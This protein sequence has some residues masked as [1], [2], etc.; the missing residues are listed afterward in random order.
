M[1][2]KLVQVATETVTSAVASVTLTGIDSDDVYMVAYNN[3]QVSG[4]VDLPMRLTIGGTADS[5]SSYE[6]AFKRLRTSASFVDGNSTGFTA[7][8]FSVRIDGTN[9]RENGIFYIYN[10][11][12]SSE[13]TFVTAE[14][15]ATSDNTAALQG[16]AGG[17]VFVKTDSVNGIQFV[18]DS[19]ANNITKGTFTLYKVV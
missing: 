13:Y 1:A 17:G 9:D 7:F 14:N 6:Y 12:S 16:S 11:N 3:A 8:D 4:A 15:V 10:A 5:T 19:G 2:G 18:D